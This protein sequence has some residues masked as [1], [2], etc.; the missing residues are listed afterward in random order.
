LE[1][2]LLQTVVY[3]FVLEILMI[4][5]VLYEYSDEIIHSGNIY[6]IVA[7]AELLKPF[8]VKKFYKITRSLKSLRFYKSTKHDGKERY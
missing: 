5:H 1:I 3:L 6:I 7:I 8:V 2:L 4:S